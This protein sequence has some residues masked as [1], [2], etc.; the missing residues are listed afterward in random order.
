MIDIKVSD[1]ISKYA[2]EQVKRYN[3]GQRGIADGNQE[4]QKTGI[5]GQSIVQDLLGLPSPDGESGFDN[6]VDFELNNKKIDVKTMGR[7]VP[8]RDYFVHNFIGLQKEYDVDIYIFC[9]LNK[10]NN[11]LTICGYIRKDELDEKANFYEKGT[12]R[13][14]SNGSTFNTKADLYEIPQSNLRKINLKE[15]LLNLK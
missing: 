11:I 14:R 15:D 8:M 13:I 4:E 1:V 3:F 6:G 12:E 7:T 9:S 5:I 2:T 10:T